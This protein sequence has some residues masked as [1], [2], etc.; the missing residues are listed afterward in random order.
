MLIGFF[1]SLTDEDAGGAAI[2]AR[3]E[4]VRRWG[5]LWQ[6]FSGGGAGPRSERQRLPPETDSDSGRG[7]GG[8][9]TLPRWVVSRVDLVI[10]SLPKP[11]VEYQFCLD[12][13]GIM[14][15]NYA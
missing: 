9:R 4:M 10:A 2:L 8:E 11:H 14:S 12:T 1:D 7:G 15:Y 5:V 6:S 3:P 13:S